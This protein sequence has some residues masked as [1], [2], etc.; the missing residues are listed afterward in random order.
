MAETLSGKAARGIRKVVAQRLEIIL[1]SPEILRS[2][3]ESL[4]QS[5]RDALE[6][7]AEFAGPMTV[8]Y[9]DV[10][11]EATLGDAGQ[12][13]MEALSA[14]GLLVA[15]VHPQTREPQL[16]L[17]EPVAE[18]LCAHSRKNVARGDHGA[19]RPGCH[20]LVNAPCILNEVLRRAW[21]DVAR[22][23]PRP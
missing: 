3:V 4:P 2:F 7:F 10:E 14:F 12:P 13:A 18:A 16:G 22:H 19:T 11:L 23:S 17:H 5:H 6:L 15:T 8:D 20:V 9:L 1:D 21:P